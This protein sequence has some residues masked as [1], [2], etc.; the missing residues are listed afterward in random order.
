GWC[1]K[2]YLACLVPRQCGLVVAPNVAMQLRTGVQAWKVRRRI[3]PRPVEEPLDV[4]ILAKLRHLGRVCVCRPHASA[5]QELLPPDRPLIRTVVVCTAGL[6]KHR[7][8]GRSHIVLE[9]GTEAR[10]LAHGTPG[11]EQWGPQDL[12]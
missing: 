12:D 1:E 6:A 3:S 2:L 7:R 4:G 11:K 9:R 5:A 10:H 8:D